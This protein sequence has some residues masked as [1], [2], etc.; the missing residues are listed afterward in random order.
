VNPDWV[1]EEPPNGWAVVGLLKERKYS[2]PEKPDSSRSL[3]TE[4]PDRFA[5]ART[6][7]AGVYSVYYFRSK[8]PPRYT[9][10]PDSFSV[11]SD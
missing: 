9:N 4:F 11:K 10:Q 6:D 7:D 8:T 5:S 2:V 1:G 3:P